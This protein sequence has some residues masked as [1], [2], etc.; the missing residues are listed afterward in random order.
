[1]S[2]PSSPAVLRTTGSSVLL[3]PTVMVAV[4]SAFSVLSVMR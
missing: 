3:P 1:M 4:S 2:T